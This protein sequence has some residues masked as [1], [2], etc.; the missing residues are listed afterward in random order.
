MAPRKPQAQANWKGSTSLRIYDVTVPIA[1]VMPVWP[2]DSRVKIEQ[3]A[4][5]A[6]GDPFNLSRLSLSCHTGTHVDA[7]YHFV[8]GGVTVDNL[9]LDVLVGPAFVAEVD[10]LEGKAI[11]VYDLAS[12]HFPH[13]TTRLLIKTSNSHFWEDRLSEFELD[14]VHLEPKTASWLVRRGIRLIG[15]DYLSVEAFGVEKH[16]VHETLLQAGVV[17][18][19]GLNLSRVPAGWCHLYCLPLKIEGGDGAPAR[20]LVVRD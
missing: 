6:R 5:I 13:D 12:L 4:S 19:E 9:S 11:Q 2:G 16:R 20:V 7:P 14:Y 1:E 17:I 3:Q 15:V 8:Q 18:I 10:R